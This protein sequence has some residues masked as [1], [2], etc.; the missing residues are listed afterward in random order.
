MSETPIRTSGGKNKIAAALLAIF[1]G[2][3]GIHRFYLKQ[4]RGIFYLLFFWTGIPGIVALIEGILFLLM[5]D[6]KW[7]AKYNQ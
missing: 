3:L 7:D 5:D 6:A 1:L 2:S 4:L